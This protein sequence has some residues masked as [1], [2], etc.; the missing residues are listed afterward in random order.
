MRSEFLAAALGKP[1][2]AN[3]KG[4]EAFD[5]YHLFAHVQ[6]EVFGRPLEPIDVPDN[7]SWAWLI[8][9]IDSHP[10]RGRWRLV[11]NDAMGLVRAG[12]G[13][14]VLMARTEWAAHIGVWFA[15][16]R[17][18]LHADPRFGVVFESTMDLKTKGWTRLRFLE[19]KEG[20]NVLHC[21]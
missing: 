19:P 12:D 2:V 16:E 11:E 18:V 13:A 20:V 1:W 6:R 21:A 14:A 7:P 4:P 5:C 9:T 15:L 17:R 3:A 10:E 8:K